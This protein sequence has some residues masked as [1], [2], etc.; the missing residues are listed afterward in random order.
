MVSILATALTTSTTMPSQLQQHHH[1]NG[2]D[3]EIV[4]KQSSNTIMEITMNNAKHARHFNNHDPQK[5]HH[6]VSSRRNSEDE[7]TMI[8]EVENKNISNNVNNEIVLDD[9]SEGNIINCQS[10]TNDNRHKNN[11][12]QQRSSSRIS[13]SF[14]RR[15]TSVLDISSLLCELPSASAKSPVYD[16]ASV[17]EDSMDDVSS[18]SHLGDTESLGSS[19][20]FHKSRANSSTQ[21]TT[22]PYSPPG[23]STTMTTDREKQRLFN[24][25]NNS[26]SDVVVGNLELSQHDQTQ[27]YFNDNNNSS[28]HHRQQHQDDERYVG[29]GRFHDDVPWKRPCMMGQ[30]HGSRPVLPPIRSFTDLR[31]DNNN[32]NN[33]EDSNGQFIQSPSADHGKINS[34]VDHH[35]SQKSWN[36][37][38]QFAAISEAYR[39]NS[40]HADIMDTVSSSTARL[41]P[42][43]SLTTQRHHS[44]ES[45]HR[46]F[47]NNN[48][49]NASLF[50]NASPRNDHPSLVSPD[51]SY[52]HHQSNISPYGY[53]R[54]HYVAAHQQPR[55]SSYAKRKR[56]NANQL[57]VLNQVFQHTFFPSTELRIQLGK[58][59]GMSPRTV[60][61]WFQNK[62]QSWR[63]KSRAT[64]NSLL[65]NNKDDD[66]QLDDNSNLDVEA[67]GAGNNENLVSRRSSNSSLS[68][69]DDDETCRR[70]IPDSPLD[71][72]YPRG[73]Y[74]TSKRSQMN[75]SAE[76]VSMA[77]NGDVSSAQNSYMA[78]HSA[79]NG[80]EY[81][82]HRSNSNGVHVITGSLHHG[83]SG[84]LTP[85]SP[86]P[87]PSSLTNQLPSPVY[88]ASSTTTVSN[89]RL[90]AFASS[91]AQ[92]YNQNTTSTSSSA[93][94][95]YDAFANNRLPTPIMANRHQPSSFGYQSTVS[96]GI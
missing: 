14:P 96:S 31:S 22:P 25:N 11:N 73:D 34:Q 3:D 21:A 92:T 17:E 48:N 37:L 60:Q 66:G 19:R 80:G 79:D 20:S 47:Q 26:S 59:L 84:V 93:N 61:I 41:P 38:E 86:L 67:N 53:E 23:I 16:S 36:H 40:S 94:N 43:S 45:N 6:N 77:S 39:T 88:S 75:N 65:N 68:C 33:N 15:K 18:P 27:H 24:N 76:N 95:G 56:A 58:Q 4:T 42:A 83:A 71:V 90:P 52:H 72:S 29:Q 51:N 8:V 28:N 81:Y 5:H 9:D 35:S 55:P 64:N 57:K 1:D 91:F 13:T 82:N 50:Q 74:F 78:Q 12:H 54:G 7:D 44:L 46:N 69:S 10:N 85:T 63:S 30:D 70:S 49:S 87:P 62:R 32:N 2:I 89:E